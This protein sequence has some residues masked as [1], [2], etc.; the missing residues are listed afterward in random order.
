M[1]NHRPSA[2]AAVIFAAG[3]GAAMYFGYQW[4]RLPHPTAAEI[5]ESIELNLAFDLKREGININQISDKQLLERRQLLRTEVELAVKTEQEDP[6]YGVAMGI[7]MLVLAL[8]QMLLAKA[9]RK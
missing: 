4:W 6:L 1:P 9:S 5:E 3:L 8:G 2:F 7:A